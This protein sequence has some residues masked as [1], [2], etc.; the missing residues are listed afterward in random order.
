M[1]MPY[2]S[3][4]NNKE[5]IITFFIFIEYLKIFKNYV[6]INWVLKKIIFWV[7]CMNYYIIDDFNIWTS[8]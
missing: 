8:Y 6:V 7:Y 3:I 2:Y 5:Y 1:E 4:L